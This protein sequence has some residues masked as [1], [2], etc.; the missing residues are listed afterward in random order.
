MAGISFGLNRGA[1]Q[2]PDKIVTGTLTVSSN[3]VELRWDTTKSLTREDIILILQAF[4]RLL[5]DGRY[6]GIGNV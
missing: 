4:E 6:A 5:E 2:S 1:D 3:D